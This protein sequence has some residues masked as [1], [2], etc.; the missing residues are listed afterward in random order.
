VAFA[1]RFVTG[2]PPREEVVVSAHNHTAS[3]SRDAF[4]FKQVLVVA[5]AS[6]SVFGLD[7]A[8]GA[9]LWTRVFGLGWAG[10]GV[11]GT[12]KPVKLY[13]LDG[14]GEGKDVVLIAQRKATNVGHLFDCEEQ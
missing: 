1:Q 3:L 5:T 11:G 10:A 2:A 14:D 6:G 12:V 8:S 4:G 7:T 13:V 9:V